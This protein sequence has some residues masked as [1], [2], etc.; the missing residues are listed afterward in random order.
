MNRNLSDKTITNATTGEIVT[1]EKTGIVKTTGDKFFMSFIHSISGFYELQSVIDTKLLIKL[2]EH[3]EFNTGKVF[4]STDRRRAACEEF[5]CSNQSITN[6]I[7][8]LKQ[9]NFI[10]GERYEFMINA[11][12]FWT[13]KMA[14]R[15]KLLKQ[16]KLRYV[17]EFQEDKENI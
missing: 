12:I 8:R 14:E 3:A 17:I 4:F 6:S 10:S 15:T 7:A 9:K 5:N 2:C 13:G 16:N 11:E 1:V